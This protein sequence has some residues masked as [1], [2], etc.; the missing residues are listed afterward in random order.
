MFELHPI[1]AQAY[2]SSDRWTEYLAWFGADRRVQA[3]ASVL[4][5]LILGKLVDLFMGRGLD[6][7]TKRT[8]ADI[9]NRIIKALRKPLFITIVLGGLG[10]A[11]DV[12]DLSQTADR[13]VNG[14]IKSLLVI[15]WFYF[16]IRLFDIV[17]TWMAFHPSRFTVVQPPA[18]PVFEIG[19][20]VVLFGI[21]IYFLILAWNANPTAWLTSAGIIGIAVGF[22]A[23]DT[24]ANLFAGVSILADAPYKI[25]DFIVL[26]G[27]RGQ[28]IKI[29]LRS[30]RILTRDDIEI[31]IPN[32][33]I[34]SSKIINES[35]GPSP[36]HRV[37]V[38]V[39][40]AYGTDVTQVRE[41]LLEVAQ[42]DV[43]VARQPEP[44]VRFRSFGDSALNFEILGWIENPMARGLTIDTLNTGVYNALMRAGIE[45][46]FPKRD[47]YIRQLPSRDLLDRDPT[48]EE[49]RRGTTER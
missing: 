25:G 3:A 12:A 19:S 23:K 40:V 28:V 39:A 31:T 16:G 9:D 34:A 2:Y 11:A 47:I 7:V 49:V 42:S 4:S 32:S 1:L 35:G 48:V 13:L 24:L 8:H 41:L 27:D 22:A 26:D 38:P 29:G 18:L 14:T 15:V 36:K 10:L 30:T 44:R 46:P 21:A 5:A 45:I 17:L 43:N 37:R 6:L 20:K 33:T